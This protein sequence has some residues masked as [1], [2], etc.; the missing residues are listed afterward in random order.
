M[1]SYPI[2]RGVDNEIEFRGLRGLYFYHAAGGLI[3][4]VFVTLLSYILGMSILPAI[5]LLAVGSGGTLIWSYTRNN[6]YGRWGA[7]KQ[8]VQRLKPSFVC[9]YRSF[10]RL[11]PVRPSSTFKTK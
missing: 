8:Q 4:S 3:A 7:V 6:R 9:Q 5:L 10:N 2:Y 11:I 1:K